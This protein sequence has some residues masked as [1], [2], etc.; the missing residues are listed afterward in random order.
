VEQVPIR[1]GFG[2]GLAA[3]EKQIKM[4]W[5]FVLILLKVRRCIFFEKNSQS[6]LSKSA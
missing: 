3:A 4:S 1:K 5:L 6:D 2:E